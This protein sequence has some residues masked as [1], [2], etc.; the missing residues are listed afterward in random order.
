MDTLKLPAASAR[1]SKAYT[2]K[3][4]DLATRPGEPTIQADAW[5]SGIVAVHRSSEPDSRLVVGA[6]VLGGKAW[7]VVAGTGPQVAAWASLA[8]KA[9]E[10]VT[11]ED[12]VT[13]DRHGPLAGPASAAR[14]RMYTAF[15]NQYAHVL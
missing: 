12:L 8:S 6:I 4:I 7:R 2:R 14:E 3:V 11:A 5:K 15:S 1:P 13:L 9:L 10:D